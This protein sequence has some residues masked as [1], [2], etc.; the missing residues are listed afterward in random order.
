M[1]RIEG[2]IIFIFF[3]DSILP[4]KRHPGVRARE[5][6]QNTVLSGC[7]CAA[8]LCRILPST[9]WDAGN[10]PQPL[11]RSLHDGTGTVNSQC[12]NSY[13]CAPNSLELC[14][15]PPEGTFRY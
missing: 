13:T 4:L 15:A 7:V 5:A 12:G 3:W 2:F 1:G 8:A 9:S 14:Q 6:H 11:L 10:A